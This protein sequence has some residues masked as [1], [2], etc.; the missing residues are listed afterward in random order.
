MQQAFCDKDCTKSKCMKCCQKDKKITCL[1]LQKS[2]SNI[3]RKRCCLFGFIPACNRVCSLKQLCCSC[4]CKKEK[5]YQGYHLYNKDNTDI[6]N[7]PFFKKIKLN[8]STSGIYDTTL[9][10]YKI[11][12]ELNLRKAYRKLYQI[13]HDDN[14]KSW[15]TFLETNFVGRYEGINEKSIRLP[16]YVLFGVLSHFLLAPNNMLEVNARIK[17]ITQQTF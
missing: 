9:N 13:E 1:H 12:L 6:E 4:S 2:L 10:N 15:E 17:N 14:H 11:V 8:F 5:L 16:Q 7:M 3:I